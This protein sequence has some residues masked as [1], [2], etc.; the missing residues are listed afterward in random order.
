MNLCGFEIESLGSRRETAAIGLALD[1]LD[2]KG[3]GELQGHVSVLI[4]P[5]KLLH[6]SNNERIQ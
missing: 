3:C 4:E 6:A 5:L 2:G 1:L